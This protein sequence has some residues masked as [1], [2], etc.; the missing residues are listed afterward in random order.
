MLE[1]MSS[2]YCQVL[3]VLNELRFEGSTSLALGRGK[4]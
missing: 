3:R 4:S 2:R 1:V